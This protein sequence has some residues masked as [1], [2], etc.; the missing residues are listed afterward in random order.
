MEAGHKQA[1]AIGPLA[2]PLQTAVDTAA[3]TAPAAAKQRTDAET[4][5]KQDN[6]Q[7]I[8]YR[9]KIVSG[10]SQ[11]AATA[12][13]ADTA[14]L[15]QS[16]NDTRTLTGDTQACTATDGQTVGLH[17]GLLSSPAQ[18]QGWFTIKQI[19]THQKRGSRMFYKVE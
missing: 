2:L 5:R 17:D 11:A 15:K 9:S 3:A 1:D 7:Q 13:C 16:T 18:N 12:R 14:V 8:F 6:K 4:A 10:T 19:L